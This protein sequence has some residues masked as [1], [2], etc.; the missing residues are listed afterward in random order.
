M[1]F[2]PFEEQ[3]EW[4]LRMIDQKFRN[5]MITAG[6]EVEL[7]KSKIVSRPTEILSIHN[8]LFNVSERGLIY[9]P[10]YKV[11]VQNLKTKKEIAII[12]DAITGKTKKCIH[13]A[14]ASLKKEP[15]KE[16]EKTFISAKTAEITSPAKKTE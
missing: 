3:P 9:K 2:V 11:T 4:I 1:P 10:M 15:A 8:E 14:P 16:P 6:K 13:Q 7:L 5:N 12:I